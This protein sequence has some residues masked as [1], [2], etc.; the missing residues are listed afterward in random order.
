[1]LLKKI[2][3]E[4]VGLYHGETEFDLVPREKYRKVRPVILFG[5]K[6]G[7]GK[8]TFFDSIRLVLYGRSALGSR[9]A[10]KDYEAYLRGLIH[11]TPQTTIPPNS[12][13]IALDF[14]YVVMGVPH[15]F[16]VTRAWEAKGKDSVKELL[17]IEQ[18]GE[19]QSNVSAQYWQGFIEEIIPE[20]LSNL[21]FFDG[22]KIRDIAEDST[23]Q[24]AL[25]EAIKTLLGLDI[26]ERLQSDLE[27]Y[28]TR[29][30]K[31]V[32]AKADQKQF[33]VFE[34]QIED[35]EDEIEKSSMRRAESVTELDGLK[36]RLEQKEIQLETEGGEFARNREQLLAQK[37]E[38]EAQLE[39]IK[40]QKRDGYEGLYPFALCPKLG[41][42]VL[43]QIRKE[44]EVRNAKVLTTELNTLH[45]RLESAFSC[46]AL[47]KKRVTGSIF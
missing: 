22:E 23:G 37:A 1:M 24:L 4:N 43:L 44:A 41:E 6:N 34:S 45:S 5:G 31:L 47:S 35:L 8:T 13:R 15:S 46:S 38:S 18:D 25:A 29:E 28:K 33:D 9:V 7:A 42:A 27:I 36:R 30:A 11:R 16:K 10:Q 19:V 17:T 39:E 3:I 32:A 2:T 20:R 12:A 26:V 14:D 21:F 40:Q